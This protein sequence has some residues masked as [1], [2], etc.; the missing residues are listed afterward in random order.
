MKNQS[1]RNFLKLTGLTFALGSFP[2]FTKQFSG[3]I[4]AQGINKDEKLKL[5]LTSYTFRNFSL[6]QTIEMTKRLGLK[7]ISLKD[8]HLPLDSTNEQI[9]QAVAEVKN[10]GLELY[11]AGVIYMASEAEVN[12]AFEYAK[13]AGLKMIIGV[14]EHE[15]LPMVE[16]KVKEYDIIVAIHNH[17][18]GDKR[19]PTPESVYD[20]IKDMDKRMGL[21]LDIGHTMRM[22]IDP[23]VPA[24]KYFDRLYE[25]HIKDETEAAPSGSTVEIGRGVIDIP[26]FLKTLIRLNYK[27]T[28]SF[29][30]EKDKEDPLPGVAE[31]LGYV[32]G[33]LSV[34]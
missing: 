9:A 20:K 19:F 11:G 34:I 33:V 14:P 29:E 21:C 15:F 17:G 13:A 5:G 25:I 26:K 3:S 7:R 10:A 32:K 1:R 22:G 18:P 31:S 27:G 2:G 24:E 12:R 8:M 4:F 16:K 23:S 28:V 30:F 6:T